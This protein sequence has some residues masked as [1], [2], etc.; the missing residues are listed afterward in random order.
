[1]KMGQQHALGLMA[2]WAALGRT[3]QEVEESGHCPVGLVRAQVGHC[4][5]CRAAQCKADVDKVE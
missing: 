4:I 1:M 3:Q 5:Q 2:G